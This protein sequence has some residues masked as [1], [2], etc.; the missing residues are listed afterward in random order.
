MGLA[1]TAPLQES[2]CVQAIVLAAGLGRR[3][4]PLTD[5]CHKAL[6]PVG[7]TTILARIVE[8]LLHVG[9][10]NITVVTGYRGADIRAYLQTRY[11]TTTFQFVDNQRYDSTN[12]IV[13]LSL[14]LEQ[15]ELEHHLLLVECDLLFNSALLERLMRGSGNVALVDRYRTCRA[16]IS[17]MGTNS[18][19]SISTALTASSVGVPCD[20]CCTCTPTRSTPTATTSWCWEC[21]PT[22]RRIESPP[23]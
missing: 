3:M 20:H 15:M 13:S 12:N 11:P 9:V 7:G 19:R 5:N 4:R 21:W 1:L 2:R 18:K 8:S 22:C 23:K 10:S 16:L 14:A 6:L 17:T